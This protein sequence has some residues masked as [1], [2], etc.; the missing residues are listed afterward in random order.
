MPLFD[1]KVLN[2]V[3]E[4]LE[5]ER[6]IPRERTLAAIEAAL[7][8][9]YKKE[10]GSR[11]QVVRAF[12]NAE[13][14]DVEFAQVKKVVSRDEV[15]MPEEEEPPQ[16]EKIRFIPEQHILVEDARHIKRD[17]QPGDEILFPLETKESFGRIAAQTAKQVIIQKIRE[18]ERESVFAEFASKEGEIVTGTVQRV[19]RGIVFVELGKATGVL[20][21]EEQIPGERFRPGERIRALLMK[22][23]ESPR[24]I[25]LRLSRAHPRFLAKLFEQE[26]PELR[27]G[28]VAIRAI[29]REPGSRS[30]VAAVSFDEHIDPVGSLVGSRGVRVSVVISEL[31]GE[32]IDVVEWSDDPAYFIEEALQPARVMDIALD[33][34]NRIAHVTVS[35][36]QLSLAIG[37]GGQNVRLAAKLTGWKIDIKPA[38]GASVKEVL[39]PELSNLVNS[40]APTSEV[41]QQEEQT[42]PASDEQPKETNS[43][44]TPEAPS[45]LE[46]E[47]LNEKEEAEEPKSATQSTQ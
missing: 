42:T 37:R 19:E 5:A 4:Q 47:A 18:A 11:G 13:T 45:Q 46:S 7:A 30:K 6:G 14:G 31:G 16:E 23:D 39:S 43:P 26:V 38:E 20:P 28:T 34:E 32:K 12:F 17:A 36:D 1:M 21:R 27:N 25:Y 40:L 9:A 8:T 29:A 3:V 33:E 2:A 22:V 15:R 41:A 44:Q 35:E 10:Y 24:G